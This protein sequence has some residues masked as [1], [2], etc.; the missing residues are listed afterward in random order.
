MSSILSQFSRNRHKYNSH[1]HWHD[2]G[3][4]RLATKWVRLATN[5]TNPR[6]FQIRFQ[7]ILALRPK[8]TEIWSEKVSDLF[9]LGAIWPTLVANWPPCNRQWF[10]LEGLS[11]S[12][13]ILMFN[14]SCEC[15]QF[16]NQYQIEYAW[17]HPFNHCI[18]KSINVLS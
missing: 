10:V 5:G 1:L 15:I 11:K 14:S 8:C 2:T 9:H 18:I 4:S 17:K 7:Y 16:E 13:L 3:M 12:E 6:L